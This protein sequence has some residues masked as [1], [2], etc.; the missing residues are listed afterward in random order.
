M[1]RAWRL[2]VLVW[3][4][5]RR[6]AGAIG[7]RRAWRIAEAL[8][9]AIRPGPD[10]LPILAFILSECGAQALAHPGLSDV[11]LVRLARRNLQLRLA[12]AGAPGS[13]GRVE[14][15]YGW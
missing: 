3:R 6:L 12:L 7:W 14:L 9:H 13:D 4:T 11:Q 5:W 10:A 15:T 2:A 1:S 8:S